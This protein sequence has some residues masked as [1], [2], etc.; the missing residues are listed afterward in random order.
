MWPFKSQVEDR[1][2]G[3]I[4]FSDAVVEAIIRAAGGTTPADPSGLAALEAAAGLYAAAFAAAQVKPAS[5]IVAGI[6]PQVRALIARDLIRRG[7]S[8]HL[9]EVDRR[10][11]RL[12]PAGSWDVRGGWQESGWWYRL[13]LFGPSGNVTRFVSGQSVIHCRYALIRPALGWV[14]AP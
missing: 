12:I 3:G 14:S 9:I 2:S 7:E 4:P 1:Q 5:E 11:V 13:D 8:L 10:G 6:S